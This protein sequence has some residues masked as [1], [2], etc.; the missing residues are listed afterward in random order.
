MLGV[1]HTAAWQDVQ[2]AI[3]RAL[4]GDILEGRK[5]DAVPLEGSSLAS[6]LRT[7]IPVIA[8]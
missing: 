3:G 6:T 5:L 1:D 2:D 7:G 4:T 8:A